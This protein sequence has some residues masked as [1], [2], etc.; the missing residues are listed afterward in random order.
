MTNARD[1]DSPIPPSADAPQ[2]AMQD[3][4]D[5]VAR[6]HG[7]NSLLFYLDGFL[8]LLALAMMFPSTVL[9]GY[10]ERF[11][12]SASAAALL[13]VVWLVGIVLPQ[14][15]VTYL[16]HRRARR[17]GLVVFGATFQ[18]L[19]LFGLWLLSLQ[20][21]EHPE[22]VFPGC[23]I[24]FGLFAL[25]CG[26][27]APVWTDWIGRVLDPRRRGRTLGLRT[28]WMSFG[29]LVGALIAGGALEGKVENSTYSH[30]F[31]A[32][33]VA[34]SL[35]LPCLWF[36]IEPNYPVATRVLSLP[37]YLQ[38]LVGV[39]REHRVFLRYVVGSAL[40]HGTLIVPGIGLW[41]ATEQ[42]ASLQT[43]EHAGAVGWT[44]DQAAGR[45]NAIMWGAQALFGL[46]AA[47]I[48]QRHGPQVALWSLAASAIALPPL[49]LLAP[50]PASF[51]LVFLAFGVFQ[52]AFF[53]A[54]L[55]TIYALTPGDDRLPYFAV[56]ELLKVPVVLLSVLGGAWL[57]DHL[58][59]EGV[60]WVVALSLAF[61]IV[62]V[63]LLPR[64]GREHG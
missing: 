40:V 27:V 55:G 22:L 29:G 30:L 45:W 52:S 48:V 15:F 32:A 57:V 64:V 20:A 59:L 38:R 7:R 21:E 60:R 18:K 37:R 12:S 4:L 17:K 1:P 53:M 62:G 16:S 34:S 26:C 63:L 2:S 41:L 61:P 5:D 11:S 47:P 3:Y 13:T 6:V 24:L 19:P 36:T 9:A 56:A 51:S 43:A 28:F 44:V 46:A 58:T 10:V 33:F 49:A 14:P 25:S 42:F 50:G 39:L 31:L 35:T 54:H 8:F 23:A